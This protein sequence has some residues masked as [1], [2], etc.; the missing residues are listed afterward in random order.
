MEVLTI[1]HAVV[2]NDVVATDLSVLQQ[3]AR[4]AELVEE[5]AVVLLQHRSNRL[6]SMVFKLDPVDL[7]QVDE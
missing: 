1:D 6:V 4:A 2:L 5:F 3:Q 7:G